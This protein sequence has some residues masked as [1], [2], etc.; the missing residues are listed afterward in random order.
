M[1]TA[2]TISM[3]F[4]PP[5]LTP[6]LIILLS[7]KRKS[8]KDFVT[9]K[10]LR[11]FSTPPGLRHREEEEEEEEEEETKKKREEEEEGGGE[12]PEELMMKRRRSWSV[13]VIRLSAPLKKRFAA[14][15]RL[16][17]DKLLDA[18][19][20]KEGFRKEMIAWGEERRRVD[21]GFFCRAAIEDVLSPFQAPASVVV[22]SLPSLPPPSSLPPPP[23][24]PLPSSPL[25]SPSL[26]SEI[27]Q[28]WIV[29][30]AR[31][32]TDLEFFRLHFPDILFTVRVSASEAC[33]RR[34]GW[35]FTPGVDDAESECGL[36]AIRDW[37]W[38]LDNNDDDDDNDVDGD[39]QRFRG[40][41]DG[42]TLIRPK[43]DFSDLLRK[44]DSMQ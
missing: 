22:H 27:P 30:D 42:S 31:R 34:R 7:G 14:E 18:S 21:S 12:N 23:L 32:L 17:F 28:I 20:Y 9:D 2:Q 39:D 3:S 41:N 35:V 8:G 38:I 44:L 40:E 4:L 29:S 37:N 43:K 36:D 15:N 24:P 19:E 11:R 10:L 26:S 16:D 6:R 25:A 33:R 1:T 13:A 5:N